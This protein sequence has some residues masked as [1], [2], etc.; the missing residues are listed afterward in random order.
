MNPLEMFQLFAIPES[1][2]LATHFVL[3]GCVTLAPGISQNL[4]PILALPAVYV[5]LS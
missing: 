2:T 4:L 3:V 5:Q 1:R